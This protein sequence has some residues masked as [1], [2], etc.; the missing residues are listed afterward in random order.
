MISKCQNIVVNRTKFSEFDDYDVDKLPTS[1]LKVVGF[2]KTYDPCAEKDVYKNVAI[3]YSAISE[4]N[5]VTPNNYF[6]SDLQK[7]SSDIR[8]VEK[9]LVRYEGK[10]VFVYRIKAKFEGNF[11]QFNI[12]DTYG[13]GTTS[14][15][16]NPEYNA[17]KTLYLSF[18]KEIP[19]GREIKV[20]IKN[21]PLYIENG[22]KNA[23]CLIDYKDLSS[24]AVNYQGEN[25]IEGSEE[26]KKTDSLRN[27]LI[28][29]KQTVINGGDS[30][31]TGNALAENRV[32][33]A[34]N[35]EL[36]D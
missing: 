12:V 5:I 10:D 14:N 25:I 4:V 30:D 33:I 34:T 26:F 31:G 24:I 6:I 8:F 1:G 27:V 9:Q 23:I 21:F 18:D 2:V 22:V 16:F 17:T 11:M 7:H 35:V 36:V 20:L 15:I 13:V 32:M 19:F 28:T 3:D 29:F